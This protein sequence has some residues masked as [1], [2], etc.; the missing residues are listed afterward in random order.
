MVG[1]VYI[2]ARKECTYEEFKNIKA[3]L[4]ET[5]KNMGFKVEGEEQE[6]FVRFEE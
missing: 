2:S 3:K 5:L 4:E 6:V 1:M